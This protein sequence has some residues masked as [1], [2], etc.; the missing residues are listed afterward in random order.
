MLFVHFY[1]IYTML[2]T[3]YAA[4]LRAFD[5]DCLRAWSNVSLR[6]LRGMSTF[7]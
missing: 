3:R 4:R 6:T 7:F 5:N 1:V 2:S